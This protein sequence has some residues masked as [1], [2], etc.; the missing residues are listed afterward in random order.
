MQEFDLVV[1]GGGSAGLKAAR[2][3]AKLGRKVAMAE[4]REVGGECFWAGCV[5]TKAMVRA[6][7]VWH[8]VRNCQE[9]GIH[10]QV[11][12]ADFADAM[13]YKERAVHR[14]EGDSPSL[15]G[16]LGKVGGTFF[17]ARAQF[18]SPHEVRMGD[19][20]ITGKQIVIATGTV[21]A[22]PPIPGLAEAGFI[23]N[24]EAVHLETLPKRMVI[25]GAGPIGLEFAQIFRR[26]GAEVTVLERDSCVLPRED[27]DISKLVAQF[28]T[29]EGIRI[30]TGVRVESVQKA[31]NGVTA[32]QLRV[33][34]SGG[35]EDLV[36]DEILVA[37]G[38]MGAFEGLNIGATGLDSD[39]RHI[40]TDHYLRTSV[41]HIWAAGDIAG[42]YLFTHV[43]SYEGKLVAMNAFADKPEPFDHRVVPRCTYIHPEVASIGCTEREAREK[44]MDV[45]TR[46][47][48][49]ADLDR[50]ILHGEP[51][52][53]VKLVLD[54]LD[55]QILGAHL[56]GPQASSIIAEL[57][58]C[59]KHHLPVTSIADTMHAYP[60][61]P[62][63]VEAAALSAPNYRGQVEGATGE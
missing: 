21:P 7:E 42:G 58:I 13:A 16:G 53:M 39:P 1:I 55:G 17:K 61:F 60:S 15:D 12:K 20:V 25:L 24:R 63:A 41:P 36:C 22:V 49:F 59:M 46:T 4:E 40:K 8:T 14:V 48:S 52:G 19:E 29:E 5:P 31:Q 54:E 26:F 3:A 35:V 38:R 62:E 44:D 47:F 34:H 18:E 50:A 33:H 6:A 27:E 56:I 2:T 51:K 9:F 30:L 43:A 32:K 57:A 10:A 45:V 23:T 28:L 11:T 37:I